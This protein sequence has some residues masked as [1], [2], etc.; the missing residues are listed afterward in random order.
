[1]SAICGFT[2]GHG[3]AKRSH[4]KQKSDGRDQ[5]G[6]PV[7]IAEMDDSMLPVVEVKT[8]NLKKM[9][10]LRVWRANRGWADYWNNM[11]QAA[12]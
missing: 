1:V 5:A 9:I 7:L 8:E 6:V 11:H 2:E 4:D 12:A 10:A 3:A